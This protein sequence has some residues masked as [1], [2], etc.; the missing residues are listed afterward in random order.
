MNY[1]VYLRTNKI[2]G[3][4]Y[5]GQTKD[6]KSRE[7]DW[8]NLSTRY[9]NKFLSKDRKEYG[10]NNFST[11]IL[12]EVHTR[13]EAWKLEK[14]FIKELNTKYPSGYNRA[15]GGK[16]SKGTKFTDEHKKLLSKIKKEAHIV[17]KSAF[18]KGDEPWNKGVK[19]CFSDETIKNMSEKQK[20]KHNSPST[21]FKKGISPW[22]KGRHHTEESKEKNR[23]A[24][25]GKVS[26]KRRP[27][28]QFTLDW[29]F[30]KEFTHLMAAAEELGLKSD[31]SIRKACREEWRSSCGYRWKFK[32]EYEEK[33]LE[34]LC[35]QELK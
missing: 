30:I 22:I 7:S 31:E 1:T 26:P 5:V 18:K 16:N 23:Q 14:K 27:I 19:N 15:D 2:N 20:G 33:L 8:R 32:D 21:E 25:L 9:A 24:H 10:L 35:S 29:V 17:P 28:L 12:A 3:K 6:F 4:Q 11:K 34:D 13:E